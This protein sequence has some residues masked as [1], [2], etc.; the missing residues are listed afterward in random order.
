MGRLRRHEKDIWEI[1][2]IKHQIS[3]LKRTLKV[4][5]IKTNWVEN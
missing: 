1:F 3:K 2:K 5:H 4:A